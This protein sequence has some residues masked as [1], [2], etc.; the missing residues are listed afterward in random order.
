MASMRE[1]TIRRPSSVSSR[2][3][4]ARGG[5]WASGL[6]VLENM[7]SMIWMRIRGCQ[8]PDGMGVRMDAEGT[9]ELHAG[10]VFVSPAVFALKRGSGSPLRRG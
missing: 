9:E 3:I 2:T 1:R 10:R 5:G 8:W 7:G 4:S 6:S